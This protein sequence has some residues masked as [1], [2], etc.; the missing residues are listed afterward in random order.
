MGSRMGPAS[1]ASAT[2]FPAGPLW[3]RS[4]RISSWDHEAPLRRTPASTSCSAR[5]RGNI[6]D[7]VTGTT[8]Q[9]VITPKIEFKPANMDLW[10]DYPHV[11]GLCFH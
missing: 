8:V 4:V 3:E 11:A 10:I 9:G 5:W 1:A 6:M 7:L 2:D